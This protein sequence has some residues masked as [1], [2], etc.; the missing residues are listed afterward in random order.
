MTPSSLCRGFRFPAEGIQHAVW[1]Y[2]CFSL[3]PRYVETILAACGTEVSYETI[4]D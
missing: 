1:L 2:R 3:S 4:R